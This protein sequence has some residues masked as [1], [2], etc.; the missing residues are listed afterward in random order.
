MTFFSRISLIITASTFCRNVVVAGRRTAAIKYCYISRGIIGD[1]INVSIIIHILRE[2]LMHISYIFI[3]T[4]NIYTYLFSI[5][6]Y[7]SFII[8]IYP[9]LIIRRLEYNIFIA[10][11]I[12]ISNVHIFNAIRHCYKHTEITIRIRS[13]LIL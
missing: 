10:V 5:D 13:S 11:S 1:E 3:P 7:F 2:K 6:L 9:Q 8:F 12:R 4:R